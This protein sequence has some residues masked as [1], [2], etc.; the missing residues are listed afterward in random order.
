MMVCCVVEIGMG[1]GNGNVNDRDGCII[2]NMI[3]RMRE[4]LNAQFIH[5]R[6]HYI[7]VQ[8]LLFSGCLMPHCALSFNPFFIILLLY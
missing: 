3:C 1:Y 7:P 5:T 8:C 4:S 6:L 2:D